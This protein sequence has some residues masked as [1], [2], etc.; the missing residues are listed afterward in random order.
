[1]PKALRWS[2]IGIGAIP[3]LVILVLVLAWAYLQTGFGQRHVAGLLGDMISDEQQQF[4]IGAIDHFGLWRVEASALT[5]SDPQGT[6]VEV[7]RA[8]LDWQWSDILDLSFYPERIAAGTVRV[9]RLPEFAADDESES[10]PISLPLLP[11][12]HIAVER[13]E[14]A[15]AIIGQAVIARIEGHEIETSEDAID[16]AFE[17]R[18]LDG[19]AGSVVAEATYR[20]AAETLALNVDLS[21]EADGLV[22]RMLEQPDLPAYHIRLAGE[23]PRTG[24]V[25]KLGV[26]LDGE[27]VSEA[28]VR[29]TLDDVVTLALDGTVR[30]APVFGEDVNALLGA[31][32]PVSFDLGWDRADRFDIRSAHLQGAS[33]ALDAAG[34]VDLAAETLAGRFT[35]DAAELAALPGLQDSGLSGAALI[36]L[37]IDSPF[38]QPAGDLSLRLASGRM[39]EYGAET[40]TAQG[41]IESLLPLDDP[42]PEIRLWLDGRL[43]GIAGLPETLRPALGD[44]ADWSVDA[45]YQLADDSVVFDAFGVRG[46]HARL[47][48]S[49]TVPPAPAEAQATV[50]LAVD[51]LSTLADLVGS[52]LAGQLDAD[53]D[54]VAN[55]DTGAI[56]ATTTATTRSLSLGDA[57]LD[58]GLGATPDLSGHVQI[59]PEGTIHFTGLQLNGQF[60]ALHGDGLYAGAEER[61]KAALR[62][63]VPSLAALSGLLGTP[64]SGSAVMEANVE[65]TLEALQAAGTLSASD[66]KAGDAALER[67]SASYEVADILGLPHGKLDA[68]LRAIGIDAS[69]GTNLALREDD[70]LALSQLRVSAPSA[71]AT[72]DLLVALDTM[73]AE[74]AL[75][76]E[77]GELKG[78]ARLA[79]LDLGGTATLAAKL[80]VEGGKQSL[81]LDLDSRNLVMT[82]DDGASYRVGALSADARLAD[83]LGDARGDV[84]LRLSDAA[85]ESM[86]LASFEFSGSGSLSDWQATAT[87]AGTVE[88]PI[89]IALAATGSAQGDAFALSLDKLDGRYG[90]LP[91]TL[92]EPA[93]M[94]V[95]ATAASVDRLALTVGEGHLTLGG[96][97]DGKRVDAS[98][99]A[100][101]FPLEL[102][103]AFVPG[104]DF[105]GNAQMDA[106]VVGVPSDPTAT[107]TLEVSDLKPMIPDA[108]T[109]KLTMQG[110]L[111]A[112]RLSA[113]LDLGGL[114]EQPIHASFEM[115]MRLSLSPF[116]LGFDENDHIE[117]RAD[118]SIDL[119]LVAPLLP[120]DEDTVRGQMRVEGT[121]G[122]TLA[123]PD[124]QG[125]AVLTDGYYENFM[126]AATLQDIRIEI[127]ATSEQILIERISA[128]GLGGGT[129]DGGGWVRLDGGDAA[130]LELNVAFNRLWVAR[131]DDASAQATG[132]IGLSGTLSEMV[133]GGNIR[134]DQADIQIP[135][136]IQES[137]VTIDVTE[138]NKPGEAPAEAEPSESSSDAE[139]ASGSVPM[140][141]DLTIDVPGRMFVRGRGLESEWAGNLTV[142]GT[143]D[144]PAFYGALHVV[145]GNFDLLGKRF[146]LAEGRIT[147]PEDAPLDPEIDMLAEATATGITAQLR[148]EGSI[149]R[150]ELSLTSQPVLPQDEVLSRVLF[151]KGVGELTAIEAVQLAQGAATLAGRG[152]TGGIVD[153]LRRTVGFDTLS[154]GA[155]GES[156]ASVSAGKYLTEDVMLKVEQG[157]QPG[158]SKVGVEI[159][160]TPNIS[161][162]TSTSGTGGSEVGANWKWD[163]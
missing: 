95:S 20:R 42:K 78:W 109:G 131:L 87:A 29:L 15:P 3:A 115:P 135:D 147:I 81:N 153:K 111:A 10:E 82:L 44:Q 50:R 126:T 151:E 60:G 137:V 80:G 51:D 75:N 136:Q 101:G 155:A 160:I 58:S 54:I 76:A 22:G 70:R 14:L 1:M 55:L 40:V 53:A 59:D 7:D 140:G 139:S 163:Y 36:T 120:L 150:P 23:G 94:H 67:L 106:R 47:S 93:S 112:G 130:P 57:S 108:P 61:V 138:V 32:A 118:G 156:G 110:E 129:V 6:L 41:R 117:G 145:R 142:G 114:A 26:V 83:A 72:G 116:A 77:F 91:V 148:M 73:L 141:L 19:K 102:I 97:Y 122:G 128:N 121:L 18:R 30:P 5:M 71:Q 65:G 79:G 35:L 89:E 85:A 33:V 27:P 21:E 63:D 92:I 88:R 9:A 105:T 134:V 46:A 143:T 157:T 104:L 48:G 84:A 25:G 144:E 127:A 62:L 159:E 113:G 52:P 24:W 31:A 34:L 133:L 100:R 99:E 11:A 56:G 149:K 8:T 86:S 158:S 107:A 13:V 125:R 2:L 66:V 43:E 98:A 74:G 45:R 12:R 162:E 152:G 38:D 39:G 49:G 64:A 161:L 69:I 17:L 68:K 37:D 96:G 119:A 90:D 16:L 132:K 124:I 4:R 103:R 123:N 28:D 154:V 146:D